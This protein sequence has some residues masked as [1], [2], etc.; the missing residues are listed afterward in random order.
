MNDRPMT[1]G[2]RTAVGRLTELSS[3]LWV[4]A[5]VF[6]AI[7]D[8]LTTGYGLT[9]AQ[10]AERGP[11]TLLLYRRFGLLALIPLKTAVMLGAYLCF[12]LLPDPHNLGIPL[13]LAAVGVFVTL[14][15]ALVILGA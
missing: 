15:N 9:I 5:V 13:G 10:V 3:H 12:L 6:Y 1:A 4:G 7:G 2:E 14:W 8:L 11:L